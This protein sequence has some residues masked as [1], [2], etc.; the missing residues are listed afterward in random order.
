MVV[1]S[2]TYSVASE[3]L[4]LCLN[5]MFSIMFHSP[6]LVQLAEPDRLA[7][8]VLNSLE[9]KSALNEHRTP[10]ELAF[11]MSRVSLSTME[12]DFVPR[13]FP[14]RAAKTTSTSY[15]A[16]TNNPSTSTSVEGGR[17]LE[18]ESSPFEGHRH[19]VSSTSV[20]QGEAIRTLLSPG[21]HSL[22]RV[23]HSNKVFQNN[24]ASPESNRVN[25]SP[26]AFGPTNQHS[27]DRF[28]AANAS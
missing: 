14:S 23:R 20:N 18:M 4:S 15:P 19:P 24:G 28:A 8:G 10:S 5:S 9:W 12:A 16:S 13:N 17:P 11:A 3:G 1:R 21:V 26:R 2:D 6:L 27:D 22:L 7:N 25:P